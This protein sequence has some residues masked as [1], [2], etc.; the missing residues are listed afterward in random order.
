MTLTELTRHVIAGK[1]LGT[2]EAET[3]AHVILGG[4]ASPIQIAAFLTA[5]HA[6]GET[7]EELVGFAKVLRALAEP[8]D[9][10]NDMILDTCGTGGDH[11]G[12]FNISTAVAFVVAGAGVRVA[13]HGNRSVTS[14]CGSADVLQELGVNIDCS[15]AVM[16]RALREVG[17]CFLF[18][19][20]YHKAMRVVAEIR[21]E[22]GF[23]TIF[24]M[25]GPLLNPA[26]ASHQLIGVF[27]QACV[28]MHAQALK[29]LGS[30]HALVVHGNDGLDE[31]STCDV[32]FAAELRG[33][34]IE[35]M[36]L[37]PEDFGF[38]RATHEQLKGGSAQENAADILAILGGHEGPKMD[39]VV[40]NA[41]AALYVAEKVNSIGA[42]IE[43]AREAVRSGAALRKLEKLRK[44]ASG[45]E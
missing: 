33:D 22:L 11:S 29:Q 43:L 35:P 7:P 31:I 18:A 12:T 26:R 21:R 19:P 25:L 41:G 14:R 1:H 39:I 4:E 20:A 28:E 5:L 8:F 24:N 2:Q 10:P 37:K 36:V 27:S 30:K 42:G 17:I 45:E 38:A 16:E 23:R 32:T 44:V 3:A 13:K 9:A 34:K 40:L 6:R 15:R